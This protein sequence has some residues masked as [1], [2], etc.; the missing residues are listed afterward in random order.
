MLSMQPQATIVSERRQR[1]LRR[2]YRL[3][4]NVEPAG[5]TLLDEIDKRAKRE[6]RARLAALRERR[7]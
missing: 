2:L 6:K 7:K 1:E 4:R 5:W 3:P